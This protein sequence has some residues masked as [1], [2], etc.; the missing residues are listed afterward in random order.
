[1]VHRTK[2]IETK[3]IERVVEDTTVQ[4]KAIAHPTDARLAHWAIE[5]LVALARRKGVELRQSYL[6]E[7]A[8]RMP[9]SSSVPGAN[10]NSCAPGSAGDVCRVGRSRKLHQATDVPCME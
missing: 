1:M 3:D 7:G 4:E 5:K 2:A 10:S 6:P 9:T 8:I